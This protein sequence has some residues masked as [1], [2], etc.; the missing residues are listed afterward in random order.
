MHLYKKGANVR[1]RA[2]DLVYHSSIQVAISY[3]KHLMQNNNSLFTPCPL[4]NTPMT[5]IQPN[6]NLYGDAR[7]ALRHQVR[8]GLC[9]VIDQ[10]EGHVKQVNERLAYVQA[11]QTMAGMSSVSAQSSEHGTNASYI[12]AFSVVSGGDHIFRP[13]WG[14]G[15]PLHYCAPWSADVCNGVTTGVLSDA[16]RRETL[17]TNTLF[18]V[19]SS[20]EENVS[21]PNVGKFKMH[22]ERNNRKGN[23]GGL[24]GFGLFKRHKKHCWIYEND[25]S[26]DDYI[27][28]LLATSEGAARNNSSINKIGKLAQ[29][30]KNKGQR[31]ANAYF[32][33]V[34]KV[35]PDEEKDLYNQ[36]AYAIRSAK[37]VVNDQS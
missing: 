8:P 7:L 23:C 4:G 35:L 10:L 12:P 11:A 13:R 19:A 26:L 21:K 24:N 22:N 16:G 37:R 20:A 15:L 9:D 17:H 33:D 18:G 1:R 27:K 34:W 29:K 31:G 2:P 36:R 14:D 6:H 30:L 25:L 28:H 3:P 5:W 32:A